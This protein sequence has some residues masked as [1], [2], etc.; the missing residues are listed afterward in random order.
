ME[1]RI[2][3]SADNL[4][5]RLHGSVQLKAAE[6]MRL[7]FGQK[8]VEVKS[9]TVVI[10]SVNGKLRVTGVAG[11][12]SGIEKLVISSASPIVVPSLR[13]QGA[14]GGSAPSYRGDIEVSAVHNQLRLVVITDM[15]VYI[16][17]VLNSEISPSYHL[18]AIKA[19]A[20]AARTYALRPRLSH[21][22]EGF[23]VCDSWLHCQYFA[24]IVS[25]ISPRYEQAIRETKNEILT[26]SGKP[27]L[28]LFSSNAGGH[29]EDYE[30][31]FSDPDTDEFPPPPL[32]YLKGVSEGKLPVG[33]PSERALRALWQEKNPDTVDAWSPQ[34]RWNVKLTADAIEA[35]MHHEIDELRKDP[36]FA[37]FIIAPR[38]G[39]FGHVKGFEAIKRG[40]S[41]VIMEL[42]VH[43]SAGDWHVKKELTIRSIFKNN[44]VKLARLKSA[45]CYFDLR[46]DRLGLLSAVDIHGLGWGHGVGMQQTGAQGWAKRGKN[47]RQI[48]VHYFMNA[49]ISKL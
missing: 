41:G 21:A 6:P 12:P 2:G 24:G 47:Y 36:Q 11:V 42:V 30:N 15:E 46:H 8:T 45:R 3:L 1:V 39:K 34:F 28:A 25:G 35:H 13:R 20:V 29:T 26:Y 38:S 43:T 16:R 49:E 48:L 27:I 7:T 44:D 5:D 19:Q 22:A 31:C 40:V 9:G 37:P 23:N 33:F 10:K 17:G 18:E 14:K 4:V 32:P